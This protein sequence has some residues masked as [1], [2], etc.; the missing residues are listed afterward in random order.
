MKN[1]YLRLVLLFVVLFAVVAGFKMNSA[2]AETGVYTL[3][4][5]RTM[6]FT[7]TASSSATIY[8]TGT[9]YDYVKYLASG[10]VSGFYTKTAYVPITLSIN[11]T[12]RITNNSS[13]N[14][15]IDMKS[16]TFQLSS[17]IFKALTRYS[18]QPGASAYVKNSNLDYSLS[19]DIGGINSNI[20]YSAD[21][22]LIVSSFTRKDTG[23]G[24][25]V[26]KGGTILVTNRD[27]VAF[28]IVGPTIPI[29][30]TGTSSTADFRYNLTKGGS[31]QATNNTTKNF[32][33]Y[34]DGTDNYEF[35]IFDEDGTLASSGVTKTPTKYVKAGQSIVL[36]NPSDASML[37]TGASPA[38]Y[39]T[40]Q[41]EPPMIT[42]TL[43]PGKSIKVLNNSG[44][45]MKL[46]TD[47]IGNGFQIAEYK[48][49]GAVD[50]YD[51][52][53]TSA[54]YIM[55]N[56]NYV[57]ITNPAFNTQ[58]IKIKIPK[59]NSV[60]SDSA[61]PA[62]LDQDIS[63]GNSVEIKNVSPTKTGLF[64]SGE[65]DYALYDS[66][67]I[68][69]YAPV[70]KSSNI[71]PDPGEKVAITNTS[72][73]NTNTSIHAPYEAFVATVRTQPVTFNRVLNVG[74]TLKTINTS[75]YSFYINA[76]GQHHYAV[77]KKDNNKVDDFDNPI[78]SAR[79]LISKDEKMITTNS[80]NQAM[81]VS[82]PYDAFDISSRAEPALYKGYL[83]AGQSAKLTNTSPALFSM[84]TDGI[85]DQASYRADDTLR[86]LDHDR[87]A[88]SLPFYNGERVTLT[89]AG[90]SQ[91]VIL[92][93][94]D[95]TTAQSSSDPALL[96][97]QLAINQSAEFINK[98]KANETVYF[99]GKHDL[100]DYDT[101]DQPNS[102][103]RGTTTT[104]R[105]VDPNQRL[106][107][108]NTDVK[109]IDAYA[110]FELF[111]GKDRTNPVTFK[112]TL[113]TK[114]SLD[115]TNKTSKTFFIYPNGTYDFA[116]YQAGQ[117]IEMGRKETSSSKSLLTS[118]RMSVTNVISTDLTVEGPYDAFT[119][120]ARTNPAL[121][122]E[123]L[124]K[125]ESI[126]AQYTGTK[127]GQVR[128]TVN[129][130]SALFSNDVLSEYGRNHTGSAVQVV[131]TGER[132]AV[133]NVDAT[134]GLVYGAYD[135]FK[136]IP[137]TNPVTFQKVLNTDENVDITNTQP[138]KSFN[139]YLNAVDNIYD[140]VKRDATGGVDGLGRAVSGGVELLEHGERIAITAPTAHSVM[141]EGSYDAF[142]IANRT[143]PALMKKALAPAQS[144]EATNIDS[145]PSRLIIEQIYDMATYD[146]T[147]ALKQYSHG[148]SGTP[149]QTLDPKAKIAIQNS[150]TIYNVVY[151]PFESF[152][153]ADRSHP[154]TFI[155]TLSTN[156][157]IAF[158]Q[159]AL[160]QMFLYFNGNPYD[161]AQYKANKE[162][163]EYG[164][165]E[166]LSQAMTKG[167]RLV[168]A[169]SGTANVT[170]QGSY[171][172]YK[173]TTVSGKPVTIK[174][175]EV[176]ESYSIRNISPGNFFV[177]L[178]GNHSYQLYNAN[179]K[180][181]IS[182]T[183][184]TASYHDVPASSRLVVTNVDVAPITVYAPTEAIKVTQGD[185][186][187]VKTLTMDQTMKATNT[188]SSS[189]T[190]SV[191]GKYD[192]AVYD[193][194]GKPV[195]YDRKTTGNSVS[196]PA[197]GYA[198]LTGQ[199]ASNTLVNGNKD[200][201]NFQ[202]QDTPALSLYTLAPNTMVKAT[203]VHDH[204]RALNVG[205]KFSYWTEQGEEQTG[206]GTVTIRAGNTTVIRNTGTTT[207][208]LYSPYGSFKMEVTTTTP[209]PV[210]PVVNPS[211]GTI[212]PADYDQQTY[213]AD[214]VDTSTGA[215]IINK[216]MMV[217]HGTV[218][219]PFQAQYYA[220][221]QGNAGLGKGWSHNFEMRLSKNNTTG[222]MTV[223][224]NAFRTNNF[225]LNSD[226]ATYTPVERA[227]R[228]DQLQKNANG[229]YTLTRYDGTHYIFAANGTL[230]SMGERGGITMTMQYDSSGKLLS[231]TEP[232][233]GAKL[234]ITY[235]AIGKVATVA[236]QAGRTSTFTYDDTGRL[237]TLTDPGSH[238]T[239]YT[240]NKNNQIVTGS[241][242]GKLVFS[243]AYDSKGRIL[244]QNDGITAHQPTTFAYSNAD[245][246]L[247][248][249]ITD[250]NGD[251][252]KRVHNI[253]YQLVEVQDGNSSKTSYTYDAQGNRTSIT[254]ALGQTAKFEYD[255]KGNLTKNTDP[256]GLSMT[257]T[258]DAKGNL[259]K[260]TGPDGNSITSTYDANSRLLSTTDT[261]GYKVS[262]EYNDKGM[263]TAATDPRG[264]KTI[265]SYNGY[266][267]DT[268]T[269][270]TGEIMKVGYDAAGRMTTQSDAEGNLSQAV[271]NDNDQL[272]SMIDPLKNKISYTYDRQDNLASVTDARGNAT[273]YTYDAN[274]Q[275]TAVRNALGGT[276]SITYDSEGNMTAVTDP[277]G[278]K[279]SFTYDAAGRLMTETNA[280]GATVKYAYDKLGRPIEAYDALNHKMYTVEYDTAGNPVKMTDALGYTY[281]STYND[282]NQLTQSVDPLK[283]TTTYGY[284]RK[285][286]LTSVKDAIQGSTSQT[287][288]AFS[289]ITQMV[290]ANGNRAKYQYDLLG[291]LTSE[292][293]EAG[294]NHSYTYNNVGLLGSDTD[295]N[296]RN[297]KY[298][299]DAAGNLSQFTD[300]AGSV[301]YDY[302]AN[303]NITSV[304]GS[305]GEV[306][307]RNYDK[308][309][310]VESFTNG[311]GQTI[312][313]AYDAAGQ[314]TGL[315]YPDGK[316]VS[317]TYQANGRLSTVTDWAG[318]QTSYT[319]DANSRL[320]STTR[321]DGTKEVRTYDAAGQV[322]TL[323]DLQA[324]GTV[325]YE[326]NYTYDQVGQV[327]NEDGGDI[328]ADLNTVTAD[329]YGPGLS[330]SLEDVMIQSEGLPQTTDSV[331]SGVQTDVYTQPASVTAD[332]YGTGDMTMTYSADNRLATVNG[333]AVKY[334]AEG[335][336]LVG[337][338]AGQMQNYTFDARNRLVEA[339][340]VQYGYD[341]ENHRTSMTV[342][343]TTTKY[344]INPEAVLS[345]VLME[346]DG[347]GK[348]TAWYVYGNGLIGRQDANGAYQSYHYDR[349]GST[350]ALTDAKGQLTDTY[351]YGTYGESLGHE[352]TT[353]QPFQYNGRDG[354]MTDP[355][356]LYQMRARYYNPEIKRF[357]NRDVLSGS[358]DDG[359][360]MNRYAYVNGNPISYIDPFGL[361]ADSDEMLKT[362]GSFLADAVPILGTVKGVQ[363]VFTGT[364][365]VTGQ[366]LSVGDRVATGVGTLISFVPGGKVVG[367][368]ATKG[369]I[370]GG[371]WLVEKLIKEKSSYAKPSEL[372]IAGSGSIMGQQ[373]KPKNIYR[374]L[375]KTSIGKETIDIIQKN[376]VEVNLSYTEPFEDI[377]GEAFGNTA[378][379]YIKNTQSLNLTAQIIIHEVTH[380]G[381]KIKGTQRAEIIAFMRGSK[382]N[383]N[384]LSVKQIREIIEMVKATYPELPYR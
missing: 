151:G 205:S 289:Q 149:S 225:M 297:S 252:Q 189:A 165:D 6:D 213:Y 344:V 312:S 105:S 306:L 368:T 127:S 177:K 99:T 23:G 246:M 131:A 327:T 274:G 52:L 169:A 44:D 380:A 304:K 94:Y 309:N 369:A 379:A 113:S 175:L 241:L 143:N 160:N 338:L 139:V 360:T 381:L 378:I 196:V 371:N 125:R 16:K 353:E 244:R 263:L 152:Q 201:F 73:S 352:G 79:H 357:V 176:G 200:H 18:V 323:K 88:K 339:G 119:I 24:E 1:K 257:L 188:S 191:D 264:G 60:I 181:T 172:A 243:N 135:T 2:S 178:A 17:Q 375:R 330:P 98:D 87:V 299:Y 204:A 316:K 142:K 64:V 148:L 270:S 58:S 3:G 320:L 50:S 166:L 128:L 240:Y 130:D 258:Y 184:T 349:R 346:T 194:S 301:S 141:I 77:Y 318:R 167:D 217:A 283:R 100:M 203:N 351:S 38:F 284:D 341:H 122:E 259:L 123:V 237:I 267:L 14:M 109:T 254:N 174:T 248:T 261:E 232:T 115:F 271:Y 185:D 221:L 51:I 282:L 70:V 266:K 228:N 67:G 332:V 12:V 140:Y 336:M 286:Q 104:Y 4:P 32:Y 192:V 361:S 182:S 37:V 311:D 319:Y 190:L 260:A 156:E 173:M 302:D 356:G 373:I 13:S 273:S 31:V 291:R 235:N 179:G 133:Q 358:I 162:V 211:V 114:Q 293:D 40:T 234:V 227:V 86:S 219:I 292:Q 20:H 82:G 103:Y 366:E 343:G 84:F 348:P 345:Q 8:V 46:L 80:G 147:G 363:E 90:S 163:R 116:E 112:K 11:Q 161:Y 367:K 329:V 154:V 216:T 193:A 144:L 229:T 303:G 335:N 61:N 310:R 183:G 28:E 19:V 209:V 168:V 57:V 97:K 39:T 34:I 277:L 35:S 10:D 328:N 249:T 223:Y 21:G 43:A 49:N 15:T 287:I 285:N 180:L 226:K 269:A 296:G 220:L 81:T 245:G 372:F 365:Y 62:L 251:I 30:I 129:Y 384:E 247:T 207:Y 238:K 342:N 199:Q 272:I 370:D 170:V 96:V 195:Q 83:N 276:L 222:Q 47:D 7:Y 333:E 59:L 313:Y 42:K 150:D 324:D 374:E 155:K 210:P 66:A 305:N 288:D 120:Q 48:S 275:L 106:A 253:N 281:T 334:D 230:Q 331:S 25:V 337:P 233:S 294:G 242:D 236:D 26:E 187:L 314:L 53:N 108:M 382:H 383:Y 206:S 262:Y 295:K 45:T 326:Y 340:G 239:E 93:P 136:V 95:V 197:D 354:V 317:Y 307:V 110:A 41:V 124:S 255:S 157:S 279:S 164:W 54:N 290:D 215:Q 214:P 265:Y 9:N 362:V 186:L 355:N 111:T 68:N 280:A 325:L 33:V 364:D 85:Y 76:S 132:V 146:S 153:L 202:D 322:L 350:L 102:Y 92:S 91:L 69:E 74:E 224:W 376:N 56:G 218:D 231:V 89:N 208:E 145:I 22:E 101:T 138:S 117:S 171:D 359:L 78:V 315:T 321:P 65:F 63:P 198:I 250:R 268:V 5:G 55:G 126:E 137:R 308:L 212:D 36:T 71:Y 300:E 118:N 347:T 158:E 298:S 75:N 256:S 278:R 121:F 27:N 134:P 377:Y 159:N 107:V 29:D 72:S